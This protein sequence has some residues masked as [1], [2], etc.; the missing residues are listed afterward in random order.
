MSNADFNLLLR[1]LTGDIRE[2]ET[3]E[4]VKEPTHVYRIEMPTGYGPFNSGLPNSHEIYEDL[5]R[6]E[7]GWPGYLLRNCPSMKREQMGVTEQAFR[8][9]HGHAAYG[10]IDLKSM[11]TWFPRP[12]RE[13][14]QPLGAKIICYCLQPGDYLLCLTESEGEIVFNP[15][16]ATIVETIDVL[17]LESKL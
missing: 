12:A 11:N 7:P 13:Y 3:G 8:E 17:E 6:D 5:T 14:L 16:S 10:C 1:L 4:P 2:G 9:A 15:K